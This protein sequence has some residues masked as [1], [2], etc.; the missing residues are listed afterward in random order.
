MTGLPRVPGLPRDPAAGR[1]VNRNTP[2]A[3]IAV[4][5][6]SASQLDP[7]G[8]P[9]SA[10]IRRVL[11]AGPTKDLLSGTWLGHAL[12]P[13]LTD[14]PIGA[15]S[16]SLVLDF[17]GGRRARPAA[18]RLIA[19][20][21]LTAIPAALTGAADW[22]DTNTRDRRVGLV[23]AAANTLAL[24]LYTASLRDRRRGKRIRG[25]ALSLAGAGALGAGG[26]LGG[27][28]VFARG[29]GV[30]VTAFESRPTDWVDVAADADIVDGEPIG[31]QHHGVEILVTRDAGKL[32]ALA[33][34]CTHR[35]APLHEGK[36][37]DGCI[38]CPWHQTIYR[39][40]DG[41]IVQG[42]ATTPAP[43][44]EVRAVNGRIEVRATP[45]EAA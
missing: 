16:S 29:L 10:A 19:F 41:A 25:R 28:L 13:I 22:G 7:L 36:Q 24:V 1:P 23:H 42:P 27:H 2:P 33:D 18:D 14:L 3:A 15:W 9:L 4:A 12:H 8:D 6:E 44:Y 11:P 39:L 20:G 35:G 37:H 31:V 45:D 21:I 32:L 30:D 38:E 26:Y 40:A 34:R 5:I 43:T 17:L